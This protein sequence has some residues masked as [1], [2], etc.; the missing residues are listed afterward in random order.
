MRSR[1]G[2]CRLALSALA[3]IAAGAFVGLAQRAADP[4]RSGFLNPPDS[5]KPRVWWHWMDGNVSKAGIKADLEWM[6][7]VGIGGFQNFDGG[8][9]SGVTLV[10]KRVD[11]LSPEWKDAFRYAAT[12]A[13]QFGLEMARA[14]SPGWSETGGP[15]VQ[16]AQ[17]MKKFVWTETR[18]EGG[19]PFTGKLAQPPSVT[20]AFQ[21][22][23]G[24]G[25]AQGAEQPSRY[26]PW[27]ADAAVVAFRV[28]DGARSLAELQPKLSS[29]GG[30]FTLATLTDGDYAKTTLLPAA[31]VGQ[32]AW[33]QFEFPAP[34]TI[35][36]MSLYSGSSGRG[37]GFGGPSNQHLEVSDNG[38]DFREV[39]EFPSGARTISFA[40]VTARFFRFTVLAQPPTAARGGFAGSGQG[41]RQGGRGPGAG[42]PA[43]PAGT[44]IAEFELYTSPRVN[45]VEDKAAFGPG[46]G[47][48]DMPTP[49]APAGSAIPKSD[50]I[51]LT[52]RMR[53]DGTLKWTPPAGNWRVLRLGYSLL[54]AFNRPAPPEA[55]GLEAD[56]LS[57]KHM[58]AY[59]TYYL[60]ELKDAAG[61]EMGQRG[62]QYILNDSW[63]AGQ[64]NWTDE[65]IA[66]FARRRGY[67]MN[68]WL[69]VL[70]GHIVESS[71]ASDRFLWDFRKTIAELTAENNYD[72][73]SEMLKQRGMKGRYSESHETGRVY[74]ADGMDVKRNAAVPMGAMWA[75][76]AQGVGSPWGGA[77][78]QNGRFQRAYAADDQESA[79]V[80]HIYGQNIA[81]AESLTGGAAY[82][83]YPETLKPTAD[84]EMAF[85]INR[86]VIHTSAHQA[87]EDLPGI[88]L[89][90]GQWF[91]RHETWAELAKPWTTYL[92]RSCFM[93]QQGVYGADI[94]Y[95]YGDDANITGLF[96]QAH[97]VLPEGY[98]FD[99]ASSDVVANRL[100]VKGGRLTTASGMSYRLLVLD[101]NAQ[102]MQLAVLRRIRDYVNAGAAVVGSKPTGSPSNSDNQTEFRRI[103]DELWGSGSGER[104]V[105]RGKVFAGMTVNDAVKA[106]KID[107]DFEYVKPQPDTLLMFVHR[108]LSDG[109]VYWVDNRHDRNENVEVTFR[110]SGKAPELWHADTG[111]IEPASYRIV[112]GRTVVPLHLNGDDAVFVVFRKPATAPSLAIAD[113]TETELAAVEGSWAVAFQPDRGAPAQA[114]FDKLA[115]WTENSD[116]GVKYFSGVATYTKTLQA[117]ASW[118][119]PGA[120]VWLDLGVVQDI[121]EVAMNG[122][123][124]AAAWR[125]P[126]RVNLT[127]ALK[128]GA[129]TLEVKVANVW[130]NRMIGDQQPG[131]HKITSTQS[132]RADSPLLP[133]GLLGPVRLLRMER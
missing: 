133:S 79:S 68:P 26:G 76:N 17:A 104:T 20:G 50:V 40:P 132:Y 30:D 96:S 56:K 43:G 78:D 109:E 83:W 24:S 58:T 117:P 85:G 73:L 103:A 69:P 8:R 60:D 37:F 6:K 1:R 65:M 90:V 121:A 129:N 127:G 28:P 34:Q 116:P 111:V 16:P 125:K 9:S 47:V 110:V 15:W 98:P 102:L 42:A 124:V 87:T 59:Y 70:V 81:A 39:A 57:R 64:A 120:E 84:V 48:S 38:Q 63:E 131:A 67:D 54:G 108:K 105:G 18:V 89:G 11:F 31:A 29:S 128:A 101:K 80:A 12:L 36:G 92:A 119:K 5:A 46:R 88:T 3:V 77:T 112:N 115:S 10:P 130:V 14:S 75:V 122:K 86:F 19:K 2:A 100:T 72:L 33:L 107:P 97:P 51:D 99:Y 49:P 113:K 45:R 55:T 13:D 66:Q 123:P 71:A 21:N 7:R 118:F 4:M 94:L 74:I 62:L 95:Y 106:L 53:P 41:G 22:T 44:P 23:A 25:N 27:Y 126:F 61:S 52:A 35:Y 114:T 93:L 82:S 32:K 91:T